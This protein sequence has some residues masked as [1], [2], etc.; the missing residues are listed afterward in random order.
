MHSAHFSKLTL[1]AYSRGSN[2]SKSADPLGVSEGGSSTHSKS[3]LEIRTMANDGPGDD[4]HYENLVDHN[5][6]PDT[7][8]VTQ[9]GVV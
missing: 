2:P 3:K 9:Q 6:Q 1:L 5:S 7:E 4:A 8:N